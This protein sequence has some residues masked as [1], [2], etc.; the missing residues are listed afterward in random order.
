M[1]LAQFKNFPSFDSKAGSLPKGN[2]ARNSLVA[3]VSPNTKS[4]GVDTTYC[5]V[6]ERWKNHSIDETVIFIMSFIHIN[7]IVCKLNEI[8]QNLI[9]NPHMVLYLALLQHLVLYNLL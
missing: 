5:P 8:H 7:L 4:G 3:F 9:I 1:A 6:G 2:L